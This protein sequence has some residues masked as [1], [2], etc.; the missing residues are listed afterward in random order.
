VC[1]AHEIWADVVLDDDD[2]LGPIFDAHS[3]IPGFGYLR[4]DII[5]AGA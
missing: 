2:D 5:G 3:H 1:S 4:R